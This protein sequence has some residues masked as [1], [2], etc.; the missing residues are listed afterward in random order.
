MYT[1]T[2]KHKRFIFR[3]KLTELTELTLDD[4]H[5]WCHD[6][7]YVFINDYKTSKCL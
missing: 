2:T 3:K 1:Y 4:E 6:I 7:R 5:F